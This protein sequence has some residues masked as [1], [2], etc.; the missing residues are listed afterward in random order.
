MPH[1]FN[2]KSIRDFLRS[3][4]DTS[5]KRL[6][7]MLGTKLTETR[8]IDTSKDKIAESYYYTRWAENENLKRAAAIYEELGKGLDYYCY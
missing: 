8:L 2:T 7:K 6:D 1:V 3:V 4:N 5:Q